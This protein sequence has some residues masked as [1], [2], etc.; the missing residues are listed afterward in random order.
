MRVVRAR[1][2]RFQFSIGDAIQRPIFFSIRKNVSYLFQF[3]I[4]D[5]FLHKPHK[6]CLAAF[7]FSIGDALWRRPKDCFEVSFQ[8]SI[9]DAAARINFGGLVPVVQVSILYWRCD[10]VVGSPPCHE[11]SVSILYWRCSQTSVIP[12]RRAIY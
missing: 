6:R 9:G 8:F 10:V 4:G 1:G 7:Q 12:P 11:F 5:A 2:I 3:S